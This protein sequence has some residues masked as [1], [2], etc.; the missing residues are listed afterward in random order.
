[1]KL[2]LWLGIRNGNWDVDAMSA[3]AGRSFRCPQDADTA[4]GRGRQ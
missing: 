4:R 2:V 1:M 3:L